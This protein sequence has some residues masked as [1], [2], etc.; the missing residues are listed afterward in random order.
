MKK[1]LSYLSNK[2]QTEINAKFN[3]LQKYKNKYQEYSSLKQQEN[4][5]SVYRH[6]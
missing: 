2:L 3:N 5:V 6:S 4:Y 1:R